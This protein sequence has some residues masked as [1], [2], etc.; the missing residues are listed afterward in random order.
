LVDGALNA[1]DADPAPR[2]ATTFVGALGTVMTGAD[3]TKLFDA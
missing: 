1:T 2:V 3:G